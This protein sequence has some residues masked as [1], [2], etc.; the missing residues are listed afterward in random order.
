MPMT[1]GWSGA[2]ALVGEVPSTQ[3]TPGC[4]Q[5]S[6]PDEPR[7]GVHEHRAVLACLVSQHG[8]ELLL[9]PVDVGHV[10]PS[11]GGDEQAARVVEHGR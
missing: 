6:W 7:I 2:A 10:A 1:L 5:A 8:G 4:G 3:F 11:G 9:H